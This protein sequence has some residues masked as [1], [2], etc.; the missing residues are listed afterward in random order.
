MGQAGHDHMPHGHHQVN[1]EEEFELGLVV[2]LVVVHL[3]A[4]VFW[5]WLLY[6]PRNTASSSS[7]SGGSSS[8]YSGKA[9]GGGKKGKAWRSPAEIL[10]RYTRANVK[11]RLGKV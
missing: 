7:S 10:S 1:K 3:V 8:A 6:H 11:A 4:L 2:V 5:M 9:E